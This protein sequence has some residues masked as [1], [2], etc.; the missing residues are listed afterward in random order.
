[1]T[2][3]SYTKVLIVDPSLIFRRTLIELLQDIVVDV[4]FEEADTFDTA[5]DILNYEPMDLVFLDIA[6]PGNNGIDLIKSIK[7][8]LPNTIIVVITNNDAAEYKEASRLHGA[9]YFLSKERA[10]G[11]RLVDVIHAAI[12]KKS[13]AQS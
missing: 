9:D 10:I 11:L 12:P 3:P 8:I 13:T 4:K 2:I 7:E 6:L 1:M 5:K